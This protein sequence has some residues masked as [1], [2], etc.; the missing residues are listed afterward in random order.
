MLSEKKLLIRVAELIAVAATLAALCL[1]VQTYRNQDSDFPVFLWGAAGMGAL[2]LT[3]LPACMLGGEYVKTV[4]KPATY[5]QRMEGLN[6]REISAI[7]RWAPASYKTAA[8][9]GILV[10]VGTALKVRKHRVPLQRKHRRGENSR[11]VP[12]PSHLLL[13]CSS[14]PRV[15]SQ[16]ARHI[17]R[18]QRR[19]TIPSS[20]PAFGRPLKSNAERRASG[21]RICVRL[22]RQWVGSGQPTWRTGYR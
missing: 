12:L 15:G 22:R 1:A 18:E 17:C 8:V 2:M 20:G 5:R 6:V 13:A 9:A 3:F 7:I 11:N 10:A 4:R 21:H 19:L 14:N 16:N